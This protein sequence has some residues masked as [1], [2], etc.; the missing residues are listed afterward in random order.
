MQLAL[1][2]ARDQHCKLHPFPE[3]LEE[4]RQTPP[5]IEETSLGV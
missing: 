2:I 3:F 4:D 5:S 1:Q